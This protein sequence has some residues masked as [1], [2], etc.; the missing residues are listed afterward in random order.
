MTIAFLDVHYEDEGA[1][2]ACVLADSWADEAPAAMYVDWIE[3]VAPYEAGSFFRRE[4]PCLVAVLR[5]LPARPAVVVVDGH[6]WL[7]AG[8]PGLGAH[9]YQA[10]E[11]TTPVVGVAKRPFG[12]APQPVAVVPVLRGAS[13]RPLYVTAV[14]MAADEAACR[15][16]A[17]AGKYRIPALLRRVDQLA[18][19]IV[20]A[21]GV[22]ERPR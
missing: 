17:M 3:T 15:V 18:R 7:A 21:T 2:A 11:R 8:R 13:R 9:L 20:V 19:D 16:R 10:L 12:D 4:L 6:V 14:G 5:L 1:R 22:T